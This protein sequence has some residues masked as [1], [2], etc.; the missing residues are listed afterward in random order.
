MCTS[1]VQQWPSLPL[2]NTQGQI[3][4]TLSNKPWL[5]ERHQYSP[6]WRKAFFCFVNSVAITLPLSSKQY[7]HKQTESQPGLT[8]HLA[9]S[10]T[11]TSIIVSHNISCYDAEQL[12]FSWITWQIRTKLLEK[13]LIMGCWH[14]QTKFNSADVESRLSSTDLELDFRKQLL[15]WTV[16]LLLT[17]PHRYFSYASLMGT[18]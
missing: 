8:H 13:L 4:I 18:I 12:A 1:D 15:V 11:H 16:I 7:M 17:C 10:L 6:S 14:C 3:H 9:L 2:F 5:A